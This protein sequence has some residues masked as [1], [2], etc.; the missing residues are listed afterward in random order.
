MVYE[1]R[2]RVSLAAIL[3][4]DGDA[5]ELGW[6]KRVNVV[7]GV[8]HALSY[9]HHDCLPPILNPDISSNNIMLDF[10]YEAAVSGFGTALFLNPDSTNWTSL[11]GTYGYVAPGNIAVLY[12]VCVTVTYLIWL[13]NYTYD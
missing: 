3:S 7:K 10:E 5:K 12:S 2:E 11:A 4:N 8:A 13:I 1:H 9:M 6:S